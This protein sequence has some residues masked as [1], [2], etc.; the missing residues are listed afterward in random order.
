MQ[1]IILA[2]G[3][4]V[5][6]WPLTT[7]K[8][9]P[10]IKILDKTI[11]E[12][13]LDQLIGIAREA[14]LIIGYKSAM[15]QEKIGLNYKGIKI[16]YIFQKKQLGTGDAAVLAK[17][18]IKNNFLLLNGD[19][20]YFKEDII[21]ILKNFPAI[22]LK[23]VLNP[24][25]F[26]VVT[27]KRGQVTD[28]CEKP[29]NPKSDLVN[30]GIY[31]LPKFIFDPKIKKSKRGEYEF[32]DF[33]KNFIKKEKLSAIITKRWIPQPFSWSLLAASEYFLEEK[34]EKRAGK[35]EK[36]AQIR[37][38]VIIEKGSVVRSG[39]YII[40]PVYIGRNCLIGPNCFIRGATSI[41]DNCRIGQAVEIK[42]SIIRDNTN[43]LHLSYVGDSVIGE[44]CNLGA[45]TIIANLRHDKKTIKTQILKEL[46]D[47]GLKKF[48]TIMGDGVKTGVGTIVYPGRKIEAGKF[49]LPGQ[50][51]NKDIL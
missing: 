23:K 6:F 11:L 40:G 45:G 35:I 30:A 18:L 7:T 21:N 47:T 1:T 44:N 41:G 24:K 19:D 8:P 20:V 38:R 42:N 17:P 34:K 9:K 10:L 5:R 14:I 29:E 51:V 50:I 39:S 22:G 28:F 25:N 46:V 36:G 49:T 12:H 2:A 48:G 15:I 27:E 37:G 32:T 3:R 13:N 16:K 31:F 33:V 4:G 43:I 26:G